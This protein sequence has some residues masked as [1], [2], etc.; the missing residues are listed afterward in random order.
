M[1][2][3]QRHHAESELFQLSISWTPWHTCCSRVSRFS[4]Q[5]PI[6]TFCSSIS[7]FS[8]RLHS[9]VAIGL[10]ALLKRKKKKDSIHK[11]IHSNL[12]FLYTGPFAMSFCCSS[13]KKCSLFLYFLG[14]VWPCNLLWPKEYGRNDAVWV[15]EPRPQGALKLHPLPSWNTV[16]RLS[17]KEAGLVDWR[18]R[19]HVE[20]NWGPPANSQHQC[21][22]WVKSSW[23]FQNSP[24]ATVN[25]QAVRN[26]HHYCFKPLSL[27]W[28]DTQQW[29]SESDSYYK[30]ILGRYHLLS[31]HLSLESK[32]PANYFLP[33]KFARKIFF[34]TTTDKK[35]IKILDI[36]REHIRNRK[37]C[38]LLYSWNASKQAR[39]SCFKRG[40]WS[41]R[42]FQGG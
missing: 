13:L 41:W 1:S 36:I 37:Y 8:L 22:T 6:V 26:L 35:V 42:I 27:G 10:P 3:E 12:L 38:L 34:P 40:W 39:L 18:V 4:L 17:Y 20:Q 29:Q 28:F 23:T 24:A 30:N 5:F 32:R 21:P 9:R 19:G 25:P 7:P 31:W 14:L 2:E 33:F 15:P 11:D 16:L